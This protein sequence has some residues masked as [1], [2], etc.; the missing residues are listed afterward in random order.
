MMPNRVGSLTAQG[1]PWFLTDKTLDKTRQDRGGFMPHDMIEMLDRVEQRDGVLARTRLE[2][3]WKSV[4][5]G[6]DEARARQRKRLEPAVH[7]TQEIVQR[8]MATR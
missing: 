2:S 8:E 3:A 7:R 1:K 5:S 4:L 6:F